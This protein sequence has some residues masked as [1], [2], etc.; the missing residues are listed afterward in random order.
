MQILF[1]FFKFRTTNEQEFI[2]KWFWKKKNSSPK[3]GDYNRCYL[4]W[5]CP[6]LD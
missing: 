4:S 5:N 3:G 2:A 1:L 6:K